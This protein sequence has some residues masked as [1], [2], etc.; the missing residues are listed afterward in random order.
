[1]AFNVIDVS[2]YQ[3]NIEFSKVQ[4]SNVDGVILR[5]GIGK[6]SDGT[7]QEDSKFQQNLSGFESVGMPLG[8]YYFSQATTEAEAITEANFVLSQ[9]RGHKVTLPLAYD[10][11]NE[12]RIRNIGK[13]Q[14]TKNIIAFC[15]TIKNAGYP[16]CLYTYLSLLQSKV[17]EQAIRDAGIDI[18]LAHYTTASHP[19]YAQK[20]CMWQYSSSGSIN[21]ILGNVDMNY[22]YKN[23]FEDGGNVMSFIPRTTAPST[24]DKNWISTRYG[25]NNH[26]LVI[27]T[28]TGSVLPNC[29]G[30]V[31]GRA[32]ELGYDEIKLCTYNADQYYNYTRD[33]YK[34][35]QTPKLGA[36]MC[37]SCPGKAG[38]VAIVEKIHGE[39]DV[40]A[41]QSNYGG[42]RFYTR[43]FDPYSWPSGY[44]FQGYI[45]CPIDYEGTGT[46]IGTPVARDK[47][48]TQVQ[49]IYD[50]IRARSNP[51][52]GDNVLG[53]ASVGIFNVLQEKD[54]TSEA[55][56]GYVWYEIEENVWVANVGSENITYL[57]PTE[58]PK[59][60]TALVK[61][62]FASTGDLKQIKAL[63]DELQIGY[64]S[65]ETG[66]LI[67][68]V[69]P[70][71]GDRDRIDALCAEKGVPCV[72]YVSTS[73]VT[74]EELTQQIEFLNKSIAEQAA[75]IK[76]LETQVSDLTEDNE[77]LTNDVKTLTDDNAKYIDVIDQINVALETLS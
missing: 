40:T 14:A 24:T 28:S 63:L 65:P 22:C 32:I 16:T 11:E 27:N 35:G 73:T 54:M 20:Y 9:W 7:V 39:R 70:S 60:Y 58:K 76:E 2:R 66:Y 47:T 44:K 18:W 41:S 55:S 45:Y 5:S 62:G 71:K 75:Q 21:G 34:R 50:A 19:E 30:Y 46:G 17:N 51:Y 8:G 52:L 29:C 10:F 72:E 74:I 23:Y 33:G 67:T 36:I 25:G 49:I 59:D 48:R 12:G 26:A 6:Y 13:D 38:H 53:F 42:T 69:A 64:T 43:R 31:H 68:K 1:M 57:P 15:T 56:N 3:G 77:K 37:W 61:I 4:S